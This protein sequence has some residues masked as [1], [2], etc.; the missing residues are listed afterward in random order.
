MSLEQFFGFDAGEGMDDKSFELFKEKMKAAAAQIAAIKKEEGK[1][2]KKEEELLKIL[3]KFIK[4]SQ[5]KELVLLISRALEQNLPAN[6]I[7]AMILLGNEEIEREIGN[8]LMLKAEENQEKALIFFREDETMPLKVKIELDMW[9]KSLL[10]QAEENPEKLLKTAY[11]VNMLENDEGDVKENKSVKVVLIQLM[12]H[13]MR[14]FLDSKNFP[15][16]YENLLEFTKFVLQGIL[17]KAEEGIKNRKL[18]K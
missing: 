3:L 1:Q 4:T 8:Y 13:V 11:D 17:N 15:N 7:L 18:L 12:A 2:K 10:F 14:E 9:M 6:F 5:K 16:N